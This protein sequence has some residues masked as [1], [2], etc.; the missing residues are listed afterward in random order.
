MACVDPT[1][2]C[3][4]AIVGAGLSGLSAAHRLVEA[5]VEDLV[6]LEAKPVAGGRALREV[7]DGVVISRGGAWT[8]PTQTDV[9]ALAAA[10]GVEV[11]STHLAG[12]DEL[13]FRDGRLLHRGPDVESAPEDRAA[14]VEEVR[15]RFAALVAQV[16]PA[17]PWACG[18][19]DHQSLRGWLLAQEDDPETVALIEETFVRPTGADPAQV[20]LLSIAAYYACA[21]GVEEHDANTVEERFAGGAGRLPELMAQRLGGRVRTAEPVR[22]V[23]SS[24]GGVTLHTGAATVHA[25]RAVLAMSPAALRNVAF[26]PALPRERRLLSERWLA[27]GMIKTSAVYDRP[28]WRESGLRGRA[29]LDRPHNVTVRDDS[30]PDGEVGILMALSYPAAGSS[31]YTL[32][33]GRADDAGLRRA[34]LLDALG[35]AFGPEARAPRLVV[36]TD[37]CSDPWVGGCLGFTPPGVLTAHGPALRRPAGRLHW[38]GTETA[39]RWPNHLNGAVDAGFRAADEILAAG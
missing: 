39:T 28:F 8:G 1:V 23:V 20:S 14:A 36:E 13:R 16:D 19:L 24:D 10:Y 37:W 6:V 31:T 34:A 5:G 35:E 18:G 30:P 12:G 9:R 38:A 25:D 29:L 3:R 11:F 21:G 2:R 32:D 4:V 33:A 22:R 27:S 17:A 7:V 15:G 26:E